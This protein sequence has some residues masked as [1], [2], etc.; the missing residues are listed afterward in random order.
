MGIGSNIIKRHGCVL[1]TKKYARYVISKKVMSQ[2]Y[3]HG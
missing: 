1:A 2:K 3:L